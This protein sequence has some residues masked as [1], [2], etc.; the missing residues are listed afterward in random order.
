LGLNF[1]GRD[2]IDDLKIN[3]NFTCFA[4]IKNKKSYETH[5]VLTTLWAVNDDSKGQFMKKFYTHFA[6]GDKHTKA[7]ALQKVQRFFLLRRYSLFLIK[8]KS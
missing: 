1:L 8:L 2:E 7:S 6:R 3:S 4:C 5:S